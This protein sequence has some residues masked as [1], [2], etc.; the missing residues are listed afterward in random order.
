MPSGNSPVPILHFP[1]SHPISCLTTFI[2][3]LC[4]SLNL[5]KCLYFFT[6]MIMYYVHYASP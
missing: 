3:V 6:Q 5:L 2:G 1:G 4:L